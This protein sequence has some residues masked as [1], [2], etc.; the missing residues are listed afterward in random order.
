M[1]ITEFTLGRVVAAVE[2]DFSPQNLVENLNLRILL[3]ETKL[4]Q[5]N[6]SLFFETFSQS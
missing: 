6:Q 2:T 4:V 5:L 3:V 1:I